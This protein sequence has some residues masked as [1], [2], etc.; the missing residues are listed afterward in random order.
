MSKS[1]VIDGIKVKVDRLV[2]DNRRLRDEAAKLVAQRDKLKASNRDLEQQ[3]AKLESRIG[4]LELREGMGG[5]P[6]DNKIARARVNRLMR[7]VDKCIAL[8]NK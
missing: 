4:V 5:N 2:E 6:E 8:L 7:E 1:A 3:I